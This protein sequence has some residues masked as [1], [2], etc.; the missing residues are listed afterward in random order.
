VIKNK[1]NY[2]CKLNLNL[3]Q[4]ILKGDKKIIIEGQTSKK[5]ELKM[6][7]NEVG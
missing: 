3:T 2:T 1:N 7:V 5:C 4:N 6:L